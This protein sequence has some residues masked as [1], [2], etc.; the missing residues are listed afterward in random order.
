MDSS[1][2]ATKRWQRT[3]E[4]WAHIQLIKVDE[5]DELIC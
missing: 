3:A 5:I 1:G 4:V 2:S